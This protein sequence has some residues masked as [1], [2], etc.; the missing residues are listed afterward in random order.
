MV[1]A[2]SD[3]VRD[4]LAVQARHL[5]DTLGRAQVVDLAGEHHQVACG[6]DRD[7]FAREQ[8]LELLLQGLHV[9]YDLQRDDEWLVVLVPQRQVRRTRA[10]GR[11]EYLHRRHDLEVGDIRVCHSDASDGFGEDEQSV[12]ARL[13]RHLADRAELPIHA[14][15]GW[16]AD[17]LCRPRSGAENHH[18]RD[19]ESERAHRLAS[20][21][22]SR[23]SNT[24]PRMISTTS[25]GFGGGSTTG[26]L[27]TAWR[28]VGLTLGICL[29][30]GPG[31]ASEAAASSEL[32]VT[33]F[34]AT[35]DVSELLRRVRRILP[36]AA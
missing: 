10:P 14:Q 24:L 9:S 3:E 13:Q 15:R 1:A 17:R 34:V 28:R 12:L 29:G 21:W 22:K 6:R 33:P 31:G 5:G 11:E 25:L 35:S 19:G 26:A 2:H 36:W 4:F 27:A 20:F 18:G 7:V 8:V 23:R 16:G 30:G 32:G